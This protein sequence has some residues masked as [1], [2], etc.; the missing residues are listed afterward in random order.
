M[1]ASHEE[2]LKKVD[3]L[4]SML[5]NSATGKGWNEAEYAKVRTELLR[6]PLVKDRLPRSVRSCRSLNDF[7]GF[8][9]PKFDHYAERSNFIREEF[10]PLFAFLEQAAVAPSDASNEE[11]LTKFDSPHIAIVWQKAL[12][13][14]S[15]DPEGAITTARS[16]LETTCKHILDE[17]GVKYDEVS[18]LP[19][20]Y[21]LVA[22]TLNLSPSQHTETVFKQILGGCWSVVEGLGTLRNRLSDAHGK[23]KAAAKPAARHAGLAV[24]LAGSMASFLIE[25]WEVGK[26]S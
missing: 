23:G 17:G 20:L 21:R 4:K 9:K 26:S 19:K 22:E 14:R 25:T 24:N 7:W 18:D 3:S 1:H 11:V 12:E 8:I 10:E 13:R 16:L 5:V 2:L 15:D 6:H